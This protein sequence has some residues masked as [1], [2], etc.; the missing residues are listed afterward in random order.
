[1]YSFTAC[2]STKVKLA[3][4]VGAGSF[5]TLAILPATYPPEIQ[6]EKIDALKGSLEAELKNNGFVVLADRLVRETCASPACPATPNRHSPAWPRAAASW[7]ALRS[8][9]MPTPPRLSPGWTTRF[10]TRR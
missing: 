8:I 7:L 4:G 9:A 2:N 3:D 1:M 6:R 10:L 5:K